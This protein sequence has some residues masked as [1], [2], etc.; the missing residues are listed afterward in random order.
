[1]QVFPVPPEW[2]F[3]R[4]STTFYNDVLLESIEFVYRRPDRLR[5]GGSQAVVSGELEKLGCDDMKAMIAANAMS[6]GVTIGP[7]RLGTS[8]GRSGGLEHLP[9]R[10]LNGGASYGF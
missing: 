4:T 5:S 9:R 1:M 10:G 8:Y 7:H 6:I 2:S 3:R